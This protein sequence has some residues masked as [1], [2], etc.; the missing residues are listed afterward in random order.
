M[1]PWLIAFVDLANGEVF[2]VVD[3]RDAAAVSG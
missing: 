3:G 1:E 2:D